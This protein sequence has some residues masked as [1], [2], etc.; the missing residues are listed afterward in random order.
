MIEVL[1]AL[2][3]WIS[4]GLVLWTYAGFPLVLLLRAARPLPAPRREGPLPSV[5]LLV[6]VH[7]EAPAIDA[8]LA[9]LATLEYPRDRLR[10]IVASDGSDDGTNE[11]VLAHGGG[12]PIEL[13]A[14]G[15]VGK[16][17]AL[18]AG[19]ARARAE[20]LVLSDADTLLEPAALRRLVEPF[21]DPSVGCVAGDFR[22]CA[23][24]GRGPGERSY[25][26]LDR[27]WKRLESRAGSATSATGQLYAIRRALVTPV[28]PGVTDDF[29][30][31][32]GAIAAGLR[33]WFEPRARAH[34]RVA[35]AGGAELRR[36]LRMMGR[37]FASVWARRGLLNPAR[38]GFYALQLFSHKL[39]RRLLGLPL[40]V[41]LLVAPLLWS[42]HPIYA[43]AA[44]LQLAF[45]GL[46]L[47]GLLLRRRRIGRTPLLALPLA[48]DAANAA[49]LVAFLS[50]LRG[51][52]A[53]VWVP[54][55]PDD[56]PLRDSGE[57]RIA[58]AGEA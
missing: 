26:S 49:G 28:P 20:I 18:D 32:T 50:F 47:L 43:A 30:V 31:S 17:A 4:A 37:G 22:Y 15:R 45:H 11:A 52:T 13:L 23:E 54:E 9:N 56:E 33:L 41:T 46:A 34:G 58:P 14:L 57:T 51:R 55:R 7:N 19:A 39:L 10:V 8:K 29:Y 27:L 44:A 16:N 12:P 25:W 21:C 53:Q 3:F 1:L 35:E 5:D 6:V 36:K 42:V 38:T 2:L 40:L 48:F 24:P